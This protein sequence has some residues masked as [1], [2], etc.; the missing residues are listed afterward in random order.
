MMDTMRS[1][2]SKTIAA[3]GLCAMTLLGSCSRDYE[4]R[5]HENVSLADGFDVEFYDTGSYSEMR[6]GKF[7]R[8]RGCLIENEG[9]IIGYDEGSDC[10][11]EDIRLSGIKSGSAL[12][13]IVSP[14]MLTR[15]C[16][17]IKGRG[18]GLVLDFRK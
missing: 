14:T 12:E 1:Y 4:Y 8:M 2:I 3:A 16:D 18:N 15:I 5:L 17:D 13:S 11:F 9:I 7:D 6:V 10:V